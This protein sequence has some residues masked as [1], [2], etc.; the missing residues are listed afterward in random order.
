MVPLSRKG[1]TKMALTIEYK[2]ETE[3]DLADLVQSL[4]MVRSISFMTK[5]FVSTRL[6][7]KEGYFELQ[8]AF[9]AILMLIEPALTHLNDE[10]MRK[11]KKQRIKQNA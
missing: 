5:K 8:D 6:E 2:A 10:M 1:E 11:P 9:N 7:L 3:D 4:L